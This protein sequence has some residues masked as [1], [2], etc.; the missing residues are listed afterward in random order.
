MDDDRKKD[1]R[2]TGPSREERLNSVFVT[3]ADTL[4][5]DYDVIELLQTLV[6]NCAEILECDAGGLMLADSEGRLQAVAS[7][8]EEA[9]LVEVLQ[10]EAGKGPCIDCF[11]TGEPVT[12]AGVDD[13]RARWPEFA[14]AA[15]D[16]GFRSVHATPLRLRGKVLGAMNLFSSRDERLGERDIATARA[17]TDIATIGILQERLIRESHLVTEQLQNALD[18]RVLIEQAKGVLSEAL[19]ISLDEAFDRLRDYARRNR[20]PLRTVAEGVATRF[21][22]PA[23][24]TARTTRQR[25]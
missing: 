7:T 18:S 11:T 10:L 16:G 21:L 24:I 19:R 9:R 15:A 22:D 25:S 8:S 20:L 13:L 14:D 6:E 4:V 12:A 3:L 23:D 5:D 2:M 1:P 17:L